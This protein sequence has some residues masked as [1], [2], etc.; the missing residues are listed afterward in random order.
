MPGETGTCPLAVAGAAG[1][2]RG[3]QSGPGWAREAGPGHG[4]ELGP[5]CQ[6]KPGPAPWLW[7][8]RLDPVM[9]ASLVPAEPERL[10]PI[11]AGPSHGWTRS[12]LPVWSWL[13]PG[14]W[15][16]SW[17]GGWFRLPGETR[18][19]PPALVVRLVSVACHASLQSWRCMGHKYTQW[20]REVATPT[21]M[22]SLCSLIEVKVARG[23]HDQM[24]Y[25]RGCAC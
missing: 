15:S 18:T 25:N 23:K 2:G 8:E 10:D 1:L 19:C 20:T 16:Q 22:H 14:G 11:M 4:R 17:E 7:L 9:A 12:W 6:G 5:G 24:A 13:G 3:C 21:Q